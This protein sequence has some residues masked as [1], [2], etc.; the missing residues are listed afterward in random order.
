MELEVIDV[1]RPIG[2]VVDQFRPI[3]LDRDI[4][5]Y[6]APQ[7]T[8]IS[9]L[10]DRNRIKQIAF[11]LIGNSAKFLEDRGK[12][13]ISIEQDIRK[14]Q[15]MISFSDD[16]PGISKSQQERPTA[17][18]DPSPAK[19]SA[20]AGRIHPCGVGTDLPQGHGSEHS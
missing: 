15:V 18:S 4:S 19:T 1:Q 20:P 7:D 11:N 10:A 12:I 17:I 2:E 3:L 13:V 5:I 14:R 6:F 16:G 8:P 9:V